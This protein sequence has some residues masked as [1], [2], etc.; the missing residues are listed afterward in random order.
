MDNM[1]ENQVQNEP[2]KMNTEPKIQQPSVAKPPV[3]TGPVGKMPQAQQQ[4]QQKV[5]QAPKQPGASLNPNDDANKMRY[6][7]LKASAEQEK[8]EE[9]KPKNE[10]INQE[11]QP[12][13]KEKSLEDMYAQLSNLENQRQEE[14]KKVGE[15][16]GT[17]L[18]ELKQKES[19]V[20]VDMATAGKNISR[21]AYDKVLKLQSKEFYKMPPEKVE[22]FLQN[23]LSQR[24]KFGVDGKDEFANLSNKDI[25]LMIMMNK[26]QH[27]LAE[28]SKSLK[29][30]DFLSKEG[31]A[32]YEIINK[33]GIK[34]LS[35][36]DKSKMKE[37]AKSGAIPYAEVQMIK[38]YMDD[39]RA[40]LPYR[41][42]EQLRKDWEGKQ[43]STKSEYENLSEQIKDKLEEV[44]DTRTQKDVSN[45]VIDRANSNLG[46][47][48][49][50]GMPK[51]MTADE[52]KRRKQ[53][54]QLLFGNWA[55]SKKLPAGRKRLLD[56]LFGL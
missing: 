52:A 29:A 5:P 20:G 26:R 39:E 49:A 22:E 31:R 36:K 6:W 17:Q 13:E 27:E 40:M 21:N 38:R 54:Q 43:A 7:A 19:S 2:Q 4:P 23:I 44:R 12:E 8:E 37:L 51:I 48:G 42:Q 10:I 47:W 55:N 11:N 16:Y 1:Q 41:E 56:K 34:S 9:Q 18:P 35:D 30:N 3:G 24:N 46:I 45:D 15:L 33:K 14:L 32:V 25:Q 28:S 50:Q 53:M